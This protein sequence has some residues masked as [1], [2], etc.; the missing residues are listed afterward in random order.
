MIRKMKKKEKKNNDEL[1]ECQF[2]HF[3]EFQKNW[4]SS[5]MF[6]TLKK[7]ESKL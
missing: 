3:W 4:R 7:T 6:V 1:D 5:H 2:Q